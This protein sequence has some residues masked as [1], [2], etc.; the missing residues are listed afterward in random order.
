MKL[1]F[2]VLTKTKSPDIA[3]HEVTFDAEMLNRTLRIIE[4]VWKS[5]LSENFYPVPSLMNC[6]SCPYRQRCTTWQG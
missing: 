6:S 3:V 1:S 4:H 5:I 2:V